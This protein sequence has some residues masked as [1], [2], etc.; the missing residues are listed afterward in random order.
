M[1]KKIIETILYSTG[2]VVAMALILIAFNVIAGAFKERV[3]LTK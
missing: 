3:D 1:K 2:G